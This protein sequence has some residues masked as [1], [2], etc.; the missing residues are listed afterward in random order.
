MQNGPGFR[1]SKADPATSLET[2]QEP[3]AGLKEDL[4]PDFAFHAESEDASDQGAPFRAAG[5]EPAATVATFDEPA[6]GIKAE[7]Q[8]GGNEQSSEQCDEEKE[9]EYRAP[10]MRGQAVKKGSECPYLDTIS[11]QVI[12]TYAA[13]FLRCLCHHRKQTKSDDNLSG[14]NQRTSWI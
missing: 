6:A 3:A 14:V 5:A 8:S 2:F 9:E 1:A 4:K 10:R 11:R 12:W 7:L 13:L